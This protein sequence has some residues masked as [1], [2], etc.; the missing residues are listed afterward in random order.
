MSPHISPVPSRLPPHNPSDQSL[1]QNIEIKPLG[2]P[3][4]QMSIT[5]WGQPTATMDTP[6]T[7][8]PSLHFSLSPPT[9][10]P[11]PCLYLGR[12]WLQSWPK[13]SQA[14][15]HSIIAY[16]KWLKTGQ[17]EDLWTHTHTPSRHR[18]YWTFTLTSG[19][20]QCCIT[21]ETCLDTS[22]CHKTYRTKTHISCDSHV[23]MPSSTGESTSKML[24]VSFPGYFQGQSLTH[25][26][27]TQ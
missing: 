18:R 14:F 17:W 8:T 12:H 7:Y 26:L 16:S 23:T 5:E 21:A 27:F 9:F 1:S 22:Q 6:A 2:C 13:I 20:V 10:S 24:V 3:T 25:P 11:I 15:Y 4:L 19:Y